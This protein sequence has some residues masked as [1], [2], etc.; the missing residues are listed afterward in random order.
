MGKKNGNGMF[1][2]EENAALATAWTDPKLK[3]YLLL[4]LVLY[5]HAVSVFHNQVEQ[6]G[7]AAA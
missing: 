1:K 5:D 6:H 2:A 7:L 4:D 3:K